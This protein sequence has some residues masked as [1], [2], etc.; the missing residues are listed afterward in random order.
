MNL[1]SYYKNIIFL[2]TEKKYPNVLDCENIK[3]EYPRQEKYGDLSTNIALVISKKLNLNPKEVATEIASMLEKER[4]IESVTVA[5][6]H[7]INMIIEKKFW[8]KFLQDLLRL[9][10][11]YPEINLGNGEKVNVEFV[12]TNPTGPMHIGHAKGAIFG[13][14]IS[15]VLDKCGYDI[16]REFYINDAGSQI[17][18]LGK[19]LNIRYLQR[20]GE[21]VKLEDDCYPGKYLVEIADELFEKYE[22]NITRFEEAEREELFKNFA[23]EQIL[24]M[25]K[26]D[27]RQLGVYHD[28]FRSEKDLIKEFKVKN[29]I[30]ELDKKELLYKGILEK[31]KGKVSEDWKLEEQLIFKAKEFGDD[32]DR[33]IEL[34][35]GSY[36]YFASDI[37]YHFDKIERGYNSMIL[38]LG[39]DHIGYKKRLQSAV[40]ALSDNTAKLNIKIC[41]LVNI[42]KDGKQ[43][44]MSKRSGQFLALKDVLEQIGKESLRFAIL[45]KDSDTVLDIDVEEIN[46][47]TKDNRLFY[48]QYASAR[49]NSILRKADE[50]NIKFA[51]DLKD[52]NFELLDT[53]HDLRIIKILA[54]YPKILE[55]SALTLDMHKIAYYL[56]EIACVFHSSW[57]QGGEEESIKFIDK[58][59][60]ELTKSRVALVKATLVVLKSGLKLLGIKAVESM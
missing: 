21:D 14:V 50:L 19:S 22:N 20:L 7:F 35:D 58:D 6:N 9:S 29:A 10:Q 32:T 5:P 53:K 51:D 2:N 11:N 28:V 30:D 47:Q 18:K 52:V 31:P 38:L 12:S 16:T 26:D 42:I 36:T 1:F 37:A 49:A 40:A 45:S 60:I 44:K 41:Q 15:N 3:V 17:D 25:I 33:V 27:L 59:N 46:K 39:A 54:L 56:Y 8:S 48:I 23:V 13:D 34:A 43:I 55:S 4:D 57:S 24:D